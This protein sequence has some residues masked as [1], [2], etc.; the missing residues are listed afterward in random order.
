[1]RADAAHP[2]QVRDVLSAILDE[3][4]IAERPHLAARIGRII[5]SAMG[6]VEG[7]HEANERAWAQ[8]L[9]Y[10]VV[11]AIGLTIW[12]GSDEVEV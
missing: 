3:H 5:D 2:D 8:V 6:L 9:E 4:E 1:M 7:E 11:D 10:P 12:P